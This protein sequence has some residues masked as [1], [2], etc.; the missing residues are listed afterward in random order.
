MTAAVPRIAYEDLPPALQEAFAARYRRLGYLGEFFRAT[1]HQPD[2][3]LAFNAFTEALKESVPSELVEAVALTCAT[4]MDNKY[5]RHQHER[6]SVRKGY[7][8]EWVAE[9]ER[10]DPDAADLSEDVKAAQRYVLAALTSRGHSAGP[11]VQALVAQIG[12]ENAVG[13][14]FLQ[15][16]YVGHALIVNSLG[17]APPVPSI[18]ED[19]FTG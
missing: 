13:V 17:I 19:G 12:V 3:L 14:M 6:L 11:A 10:L 16:R 2:A 15:A 4:W 7:G 18:F 8:R 9:V 5:E 1:A